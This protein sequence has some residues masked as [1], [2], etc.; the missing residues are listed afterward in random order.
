MSGIVGIYHLNQCPVESHDLSRMVDVLA[1]RGPDG[2]D[3]WCNGAVGFGHRMLWTTPESLH[4]QLP[5]VKGELA[6]TADARIDN[7]DDLI[8]ILGLKSLPAEKIADSQL[9]LAAYERWGNQCLDKLIGDFAFAIWDGRKQ[10]L[11]CAR[12]PMGIKPFYYYYSNQVF[13]FAS[14]IKALLCLP[15]VPRR[16]NEL[17]VA[18][19][20]AMFGG[21]PVNTF[22]QEIFKLPAVHYLTID[23]TRAKKIQK[24]WSLDPKREIRLSSDQ[25]YVEAF[26]EVFTEAVRCRLRSAFPVGSTLSGGLDS[27]S[28]ACTARQLFRQSGGQKLHTF[29]AIFP[30]LPL[31]DR[32][33][34]DER[35]Y[36]DTVKQLEG[37][38]SHD[39]RA[40]QLNPFI[41]LL[42]Q[43]E[44][45]ICA[46]N[47]YIHQGLY[48]CAQQHGVRVFLDGI[49][50]DSTISHGWPYLT[51]L[52]Y[53]GRWY[54]LFKVMA[55][56]AKHHRISRQTILQ[57]QV[58]SPLFIDPVSNI[59]Q[60]LCQLVNQPQLD[61]TL[62][63][64][65][66]AHQVELSAHLQRLTDTQLWQISPRKQHFLSL[67]TALYPHVMEITDKTAAKSSLE[68]RYPFFDRRLMEFCLAL[69]SEQKFRQGWSRAILRFAMTDILPAK[70]QWRPGKG[71]L[72]AN[73]VRRFLELEKTSLEN[74]MLQSQVLQ[75][76]VNDEI[77][78]SAYEC[79][80]T[81]NQSSKED[82][83]TLLAGVTLEKWLH[84]TPD[85][86][87]LS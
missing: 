71:R 10:S 57:M 48:H 29:S 74:M 79:C 65:T 34:I 62:V 8:E 4:E 12:D 23:H 64:S 73:F 6:I 7:R 49:D 14:E 33:W 26:Q 70:I 51:E 9:I 46:P 82:A 52:A 39:V 59:W 75:S 40:D 43:D 15:D 86:N 25:E 67:T 3:I 54:T 81:H 56:A 42:W 11:L 20:L 32:R 85:I 61:N 77:L 58:L 44:E 21:D 30:S 69:P 41:D 80:V 2:A 68:G 47:L 19:H 5:L 28:I 22:Y 84:Q 24:Y 78:K 16:L 87:T 13:Y 36:M 55:A 72:G 38:D 45:P 63:N 27:S 50:G 1:H 76:Y 83:M 31:E 60:R 37:I 35:Q 18:C 66:F 53:T 17:K